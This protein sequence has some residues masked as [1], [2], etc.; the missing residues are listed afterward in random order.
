MLSFTENNKTLS[1]VFIYDRKKY[2]N[3]K[4]IY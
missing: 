3:N 2:A 1:F 4:H